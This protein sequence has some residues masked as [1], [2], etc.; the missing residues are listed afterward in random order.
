MD[1]DPHEKS[2]PQFESR[3]NI[4]TSPA[5]PVTIR[6]AGRDGVQA[7]IGNISLGGFFVALPKPPPAGTRV[8]FALDLDGEVARGYGEVAWIHLT[9]RSLERPL[10]MGVQ[11]QH[12]RKEGETLLR[13]FLTRD[14]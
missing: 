8:L 10:G 12:F 3:E 5:V 13:H 6:S 14:P 4:R 9:R 2:H 11:F 7:R 1:R